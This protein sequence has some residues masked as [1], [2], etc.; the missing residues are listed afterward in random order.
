MDEASPDRRDLTL[1][2][3]TDVITDDPSEGRHRIL[4]FTAAVAVH[5]LLFSLNL[6]IRA[7][8]PPP[9]DERDPNR[10]H[11]LTIFTPP[12]ELTLPPRP[13]V[14][15]IPI[16]GPD[17]QEPDIVTR[18]EVEAPVDFT[19]DA[20]EPP[21]FGPPPP[22]PEPVVAEPVEVVFMT[23]PPRVI[24][25]V[26]PHYPEPAHRLGVDGTVILEMVIDERGVP[27]GLTVLRG[28][29]FG[30]TEAAVAAARQWRFE[31]CTSGGKP[32]KARFTLTVRFVRR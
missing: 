15:S 5:L 14:K 32:V 25:R 10:R 9:V 11:V 24:H 17:T 1:G 28:G 4:A 22:P 2:S 21:V 13:D 27:E 6:P 29:P 16:P 19:P 23:E 31:P 30:L 12:Q 7:D 18:R 3:L 8:Q 26:E 20:G